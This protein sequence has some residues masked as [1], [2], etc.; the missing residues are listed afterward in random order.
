LFYT[1]NLNFYNVCA[2]CYLIAPVINVE[3]IEIPEN[4][5]TTN[6]YIVWAINSTDLDGDENTT[7]AI[8]SQSDPGTFEINA[9]NEIVTSAKFDYETTK[10]YTVVLK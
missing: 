6:V 8:M 10:N 2:F 5:N 1:Y 9:D 4:V 7:F 3:D